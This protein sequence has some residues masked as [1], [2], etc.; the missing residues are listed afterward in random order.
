MTKKIGIFAVSLLLLLGCEQT[1]HGNVGAD[2]YY[3]EKETFTRTS[4][5]INVILYKSDTE[6]KAAYMQKY[7]NL[8]PNREVVAFSTLNTGGTETCTIS[9]VDPKT[10]YVPEFIGHEVTHCIYGEWH[11]IQ[12]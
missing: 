12:P 3:F 7:N 6:L 2:G 4:L 1:Q 9:M 5:Q 8:P 11:K 10:H